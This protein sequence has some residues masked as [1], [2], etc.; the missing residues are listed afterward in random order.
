MVDEVAE[1]KEYLDGKGLS[2]HRNYYRACYMI[3]KYY[4]KL[5]LTK[6]AAFQKAAAWVRQYGL[7]LPFSLVT[8][9]TAAYVNERELR[10]G[11]T[12]WISKDDAET[13]RKYA[14]NK[15]DRRVALALLCC[16]KAF[17]EED[18]SFVAS[19][20]ALASWLGMDP[21]NLRQRSLKRL[22][23][24]GYVDRLEEDGSLHGWQKNYYRNAYKFRLSVPYGRDGQW[25][26]VNN[27]I[28]SLY[29]T[30]FSEAW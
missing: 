3:S 28:R 22:E 30:V 29:E 9:V 11:A 4:K 1:V 6:K 8:C 17:S 21:A 15:Q 19:G 20:S 18:G 23:E 10:C 14:A 25:E 26:L 27:D 16:A 7:T 24:F 5:G 2:D 13:I 12:V